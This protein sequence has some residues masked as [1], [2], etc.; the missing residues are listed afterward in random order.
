[1]RIRP[2]FAQWF[3]FHITIET[4]LDGHRKPYLPLDER[5][6]AEEY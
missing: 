3:G 2:L 1:M 5:I 4:M 6:V